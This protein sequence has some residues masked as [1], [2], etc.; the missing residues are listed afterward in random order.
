LLRQSS[1]HE[2]LLR[3]LEKV[4]ENFLGWL[5]EAF[6]LFGNSRE[7]VAAGQGDQIVLIFDQCVIYYSFL[8]FSENYTSM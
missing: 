4:L 3:K 8:Q 7:I 5:L 6:I 2:T 1:S